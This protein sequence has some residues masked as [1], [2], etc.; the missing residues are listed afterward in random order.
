[1]RMS[2][3]KIVFEMIAA[4]FEDIVIFILDL[5]ACAPDLP[6]AV[7]R[8]RRNGVVSDERVVIEDC[9]RLL[10]GHGQFQPVDQ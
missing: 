10:M 4:I 1:M 2:V 9:S 3:S 6:E 5:P 8:C 7:D